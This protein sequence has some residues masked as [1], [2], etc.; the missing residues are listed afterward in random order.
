MWCCRCCC[1]YGEEKDF[2]GICLLLFPSI[3]SCWEE[4]QQRYRTTQLDRDEEGGF[5]RVDLTICC[6]PRGFRYTQTALLHTYSSKY[7]LGIRKVD[8]M[9]GFFKRIQG[10]NHE[11][12]NKC[13]R[14]ELNSV[15][16]LLLQSSCQSSCLAARR[17]REVQFVTF[18]STALNPNQSMIF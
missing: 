17:R 10:D 16:K 14:L 3:A 4:Q 8:A 2:V 5:I 9:E 7:I 11:R 1:C 6:N 18:Y 12:R 13:F 15:T